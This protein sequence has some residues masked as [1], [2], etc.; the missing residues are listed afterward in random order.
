MRVEAHG[1]LVPT[2]GGDPIPLDRAKLSIGRR[3]S[4]D[5]PLRYPNVSG[6]HCELYF[7]DGYWYIRDMG[8][9]NG[10][11]VN[12]TRIHQKKLLRPK[13]QIAVANHRFTI[14]YVMPLEKDGH[15]EPVEEDLGTSLLE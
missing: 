13:D 1:E 4:C 6:K 5:V 7:L 14:S 12:G 10:T 15:L 2:G 9:T 3:E 8:S 11:K